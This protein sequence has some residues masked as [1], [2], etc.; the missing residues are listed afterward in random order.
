M[1]LLNQSEL[2][3]QVVLIIAA[4]AKIITTTYFLL[5]LRNLASTIPILANKLRTTG[6]L[7]ADSK[8]K[9]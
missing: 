7:K 6:K 5:S 8:C 9:N 1:V 3:D 2:W 4:A